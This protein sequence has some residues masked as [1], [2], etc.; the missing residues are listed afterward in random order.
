MLTIQLTLPD[1]KTINFEDFIEN[2]VCVIPP[3]KSIHTLT[4]SINMDNL[5]KIKKHFRKF[6]DFYYLYKIE[7]TRDNTIYQQ[8]YNKFMV[9]IWKKVKML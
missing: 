1:G 4:L 3:K 5:K 2:E 6:D 7:K 9:E 8:Q